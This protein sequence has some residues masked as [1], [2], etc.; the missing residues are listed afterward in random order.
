MDPSTGAQPL[1]NQSKS[2]A[3]TVNGEIWNH[4]TL[5]KGLVDRHE[6]ATASD[7]EPIVYLYEEEGDEFV[8]KLDG[9][10][11][12][13]ISDQE[14]GTVLAARDQIGVCPMYIGWG[15]DGSVWFASEMKA[16]SEGKRINKRRTIMDESRCY[17]YHYITLYEREYPQ[18]LAYVI[19][20]FPYPI[21]HYL[22]LFLCFSFYR[23]RAI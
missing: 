7:C 16:L 23:L 17:I 9:I 10:F 21:S 2:I 13:V 3:L 12:F 14:K 4:E 6:F 20:L 5:R 11:A 1:Y 22:S 8:K 15:R 18:L 19:P